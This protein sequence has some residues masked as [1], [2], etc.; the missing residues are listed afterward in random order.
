MSTTVERRRM[1]RAAT[2]GVFAAIALLASGPAFEQTP[3]SPYQLA[4]ERGC[5][6]CH[7]VES[8]PRGSTGL[9]PS[10]PPFEEIA[11]RYRADPA[12]PSR[13]ASIVRYGT[14]PLRRDRHWDGKASFTTMYSNDVIVSDEE[15][16]YLVEWILTL[17]SAHNASRSTQPQRT[18]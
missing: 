6:L 8:P 11:R 3:A 16:R 18:P 17:G 10:A 5:T 13:L 4:R 2:G 9:L 15:S 14:G 12:A 1:A 7:E